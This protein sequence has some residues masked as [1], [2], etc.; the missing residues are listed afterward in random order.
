MRS[1]CRPRWMRAVEAIGV[2]ADSLMKQMK[3]WDLESGQVCLCTPYAPGHWF[4]VGNAMARN[5]LIYAG[6]QATVVVASDL[7]SGGTWAGA[8]EALKGNL[9]PVLVRQGGGRAI[10]S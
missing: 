9:C 6:S 10:Q 2:V 3:K 4:P 5:R 8:T 1:R 7:D